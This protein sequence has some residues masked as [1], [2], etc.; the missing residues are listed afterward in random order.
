MA[1]R[2]PRLPSV[3]PAWSI[4]QLWWQRV[5][6]QLEAQE[7]AQDAVI[8]RIR[9][10]LSHTDPTSI[11]TAADAGANSTITVA[12]HVRVYADGTT[13][14]ITGI[15]PLTGLT[16]ATSYGLYY[17]DLTLALTT[18]VVVATTTLKDS[19]AAAAEGRHF[20][21]VIKTPTA[22]SGK[23]YVG[24]GAYPANSSIGGEI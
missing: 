14:N 9:R 13:V 11:L 4:F 24:G 23:S 17:D 20:L 6:E 22:G 21:G 2:L 19:Y 3:Q 15:P 16:S 7:T 5:V 12:N 10:L 1:F 8:N 18:P